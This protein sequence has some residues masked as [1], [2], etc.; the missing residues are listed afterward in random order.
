MNLQ[1]LKRLLSYVGH[2]KGKFISSV[3]MCVIGTVLTVLAPLVLG[4]ITTILYS[5][6]VDGYWFVD[7]AA[8]GSVIEESVYLWAG[9][10]GGVAVGKIPAAI[11][12]SVIVA[13]L[14]GLSMVFCSI[15]NKGLSRI[16][17][18]IVHDLRS[19]IEDKMHKLTLN[20]YATRANG[21]ILSVITNDVD[22]INALL[23]KFS[24]QVVNNAVSLIGTLIMLLMINGWLAL[25]AVL[26]IP[27]TLL[28]TGPAQKISAK[29]YSGQQNMLGTVNGYV[30]EMYNGQ[31]VVTS[32][33]YQDK[34]IAK[35]DEMNE[36][37]QG[38]TEK[39][40]TFS[41]AVMPIT[42][43]VNNIGYAV[44]ALVGCIF[45]IQ[46]TMTVGNVQSALQYT[47]NFQ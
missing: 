28:L 42:Q 47:K 24:Y 43:A 3:L 5:G 21:D 8:D 33:N 31:N 25:I 29:N 44:S 12:T 38:K 17:A 27:G 39:A 9:G 26:M 10:D 30:E 40:E 16:A 2:Y 19:D 46:G 22:A 11:V 34:A 32:F 45:A 18:L 14:Y 4:E 6:V 23:G 1:V 20:Y 36:E 35:F 37:L 41:G 13:I 15:A 7:Y